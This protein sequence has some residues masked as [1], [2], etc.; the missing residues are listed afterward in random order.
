MTGQTTYPFILGGL[1]TGLASTC[2]HPL[3]LAKVRM[4][5]AYGNVGL[6]KT[7]RLVVQDRGLQ[8]RQSWGIKAETFWYQ[9]HWVCLMV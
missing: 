4:Q 3:D 6:V 1:A 2:T 7:L 5:T 9:G 8:N